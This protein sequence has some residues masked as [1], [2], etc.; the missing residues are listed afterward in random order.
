MAYVHR[1]KKSG[2]ILQSTNFANPKSASKHSEHL[3]PI[4]SVIKSISR[5]KG[6]LFLL[7]RVLLLIS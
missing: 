3:A 7:D 2:P 6:I 5:T 1:K 4:I